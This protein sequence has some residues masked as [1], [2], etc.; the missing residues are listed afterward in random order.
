MLFITK[1][2]KILEFSLFMMDQAYYVNISCHSYGKLQYS[3]HN[4]KFRKQFYVKYILP[5]CKAR[6]GHSLAD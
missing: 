6:Q 5:R 1:T 4:I 3:D 2:S